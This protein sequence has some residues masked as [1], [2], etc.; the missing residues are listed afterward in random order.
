MPKAK[1]GGATPTP[2]KLTRQARALLPLIGRSPK[3][4]PNATEGVERLVLAMPLILQAIALLK[5]SEDLEG[6]ALAQDLEEILGAPA[7]SELAEV[8][9]RDE[10]GKVIGWML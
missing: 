7:V 4:R 10:A 9:I 6:W 1:A 8:E 3:G 2:M 5:E